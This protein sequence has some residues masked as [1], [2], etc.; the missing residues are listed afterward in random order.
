MRTTII[1]PCLPQPLEDVS[2]YKFLPALTGKRA[3]SDMEHALLALQMWLGGMGIV[4]PT[5]I[6]VSLYMASISITAP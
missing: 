4:N 5:I 3:F 1:D 2:R 6:S